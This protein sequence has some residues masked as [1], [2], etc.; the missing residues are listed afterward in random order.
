MNRLERSEVRERVLLVHGLAAPRWLLIPIQQRLRKAG[1]L[2]TNWGYPSIRGTIQSQAGKLGRK[3]ESLE[4][5]GD[6]RQ[7]H[8]VT[9]SMGCVITRYLLL[10]SKPATLGRWV[11]LTP[12]H[13]G[14]P[15]ATF[16]ARGL[17][18]CC[19]PLE[20]LSDSPDSFVNELGVPEGI[21]TGV[22]AARHDRV[23]DVE[24]THLPGERDHRV[25]S[26][27]HSSLLFRRDVAEA[28]VHFLRQGNFGETL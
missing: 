2:T 11:Q 5:R 25:V 24:T 6:H 13:H 1:Y 20:Q 4:Q 22:I 18:W 21:E 27:G 26:S 8:L 7:L 9:H 3:I 12:P 15:V 28:V 14:S 16:L 23:I 17:A 19:E 10:T